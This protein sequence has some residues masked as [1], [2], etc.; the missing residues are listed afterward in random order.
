MQ[1]ESNPINLFLHVRPT[2]HPTFWQLVL[3]PVLIIVC[4]FCTFA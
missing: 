1:F 3:E 2:N 4:V